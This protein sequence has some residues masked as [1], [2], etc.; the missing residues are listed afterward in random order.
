MTDEKKTL[1]S[2][3]F[4]NMHT[5]SYNTQLRTET[6]FTEGVDENGELIAVENEVERNYLLIQVPHRTAIEMADNYGFT[7]DQKE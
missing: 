1:L 4:W 6:E 5:I 7:D 3:I 2:D